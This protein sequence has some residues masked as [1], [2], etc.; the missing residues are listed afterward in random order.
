MQKLPQAAAA[1]LGL[2]CLAAIL[3]VTSPTRAA[4]SDSPS[5]YWGASINGGRYGYGWVPQ[6]MRGVAAFESHAG[7]NVSIIH[8]GQTWETSSGAWNGFSPTYFD[9]I[10]NHGSIPFF[11]WM[12][13]GGGGATQ[14]AFC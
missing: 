1:L 4:D 9:N 6:D 2:V 3:S 5:I 11:A 8:F 7:K 14:P 10:R 13:S 12:S